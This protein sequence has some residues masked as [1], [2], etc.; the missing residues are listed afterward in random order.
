MAVLDTDIL[1][2]YLKGNDFVIDQLSTISKSEPLCTTTL[3][4]Y[5]LLRGSLFSP[6]QWNI[7]EELLSNLIILN[8]DMS[9]IELA[10]KKYFQFS[11]E[12]KKPSEFDHLIACICISNNQSLITRNIKDYQNYEELKLI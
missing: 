9:I 6:D 3:N 4:C 7:A 2:E 10:S 12:G 8:I 1:I 11:K 5:E